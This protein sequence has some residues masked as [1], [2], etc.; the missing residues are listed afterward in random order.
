MVGLR[1][2]EAEEVQH[3]DDHVELAGDAQ[4][5]QEVGEQELHEVAGSATSAGVERRW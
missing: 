2:A 3:A 4:V 1:Q 5:E